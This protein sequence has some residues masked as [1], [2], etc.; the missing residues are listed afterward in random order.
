MPSRIPF[1]ARLRR[2]AGGFCAILALSAALSG[3]AARVTTVANLPPGVTQT[4]V[5][6]WDSAVSDLGKVAATTS[7][8]RQAA[9]AANQPPI[10][11]F[12]GNQGVYVAMLRSIARVDQAQ[13]AAANF[14]QTVPDNW[15]ASTAAQVQGYVK[16]ILAELAT[17]TQQ[18]LPGISNAT[19]KQQIGQLIAEIQAAANLVL[20]LTQ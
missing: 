3:C 2:V 1:P 14:L 19:A 5:T 20:A 16:A 12:A 17:E 4:E 9:I 15:S 13:I 8:L 6:H 10:S 11:A 18:G 7:A